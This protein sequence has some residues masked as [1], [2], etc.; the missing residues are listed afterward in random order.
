M[1][2]LLAILVLCLSLMSAI[3]IPA[4]ADYMNGAGGGGGGGSGTVTTVTG[5]SPIVITSNP[6]TTP[7][8]TLTVVPLALGG[9]NTSTV[10]TSAQIPIAN[11][12]ATAYVPET[13]SADATLANNGALTLAT[14]NS[15]VGS[16]TNANIT[17]NAKGLVT[18]AANGTGGGGGFTAANKSTSFT[19]AAQNVY[20]CSA[21]LTCTLP[22]AA[23]VGGQEI[24]VIITAGS[25]TITFNTTGGQ[26]ISGQASGA[27]TGTAQ[28]NAYRFISDG[29]NWF[30]E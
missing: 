19:A 25:T 11:A 26:T 17:V 4:L 1:K 7:N 18:A 28:Y 5:S 20:F 13:V 27:I 21:T 15:N 30:L 3:G 29:S 9:L 23:S 16:F 22:T 6:T 12:G 2:R 10:P 8:V 14:V 24:E